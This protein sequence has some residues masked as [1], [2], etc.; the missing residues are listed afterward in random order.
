MKKSSVGTRLLGKDF[1]CVEWQAPGEILIGRSHQ[2]SY[3]WL[4]DIEMPSNWGCGLRKHQHVGGRRKQTGVKRGKSR[5]GWEQAVFE[6]LEGPENV[7]GWCGKRWGSQGYPFP[8]PLLSGRPALL[9]TGKRSR[10]PVTHSKSLGQIPSES[11]PTAKLFGYKYDLIRSLRCSS[12]SELRHCWFHF[13]QE[14]G[15]S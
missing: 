9:F 11:D 2:L 6:H 15:P 5:A 7:R 1:R 10:S 14:E 3:A 4:C 12:Q 13:R 8:H